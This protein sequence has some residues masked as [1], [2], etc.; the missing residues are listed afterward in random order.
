[1]AQFIKAGWGFDVQHDFARAK[2]DTPIEIDVEAHSKPGHVV[3]YIKGDPDSSLSSCVI[4]RS[5]FT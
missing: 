3:G 2:V 1:M 4:R 5:A